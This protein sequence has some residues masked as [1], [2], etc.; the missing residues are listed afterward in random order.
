MHTTPSLQTLKTS[1]LSVST[2]QW[3]GAQ[4][5]NFS[6]LLAKL[7]GQPGTGEDP[8]DHGKDICQLYDRRPKG[9]RAQGEADQS[10]GAVMQTH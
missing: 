7:Q 8:K 6:Q 3:K 1:R 10:R 9:S 4:A 5:L 2:W